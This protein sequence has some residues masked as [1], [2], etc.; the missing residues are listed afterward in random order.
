MRPYSTFCF[1]AAV[2]MRRSLVYAVY[3][4]KNIGET[5]NGI[6]QG[7]VDDCSCA[8]VSLATQPSGCIT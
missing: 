7:R 2:V 8:R 5:P 4:L 6:A 1:L 3:E